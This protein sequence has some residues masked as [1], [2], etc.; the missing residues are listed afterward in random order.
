MNSSNIEKPNRGLQPNALT[1]H[2]WNIL[3]C[4][5]DFFAADVEFWLTAL[6]NYGNVNILAI[7]GIEDLFQAMPNRGICE[8]IENLKFLALCKKLLLY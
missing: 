4:A 6:H 1:E 2:D 8:V 7:L 3:L 5:E